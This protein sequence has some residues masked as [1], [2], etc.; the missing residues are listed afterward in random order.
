MLTISNKIELLSEKTGKTVYFIKEKLGITPEIEKELKVIDE[1][2]T[3][4]EITEV[5]QKY[6][7]SH[8]IVYVEI[9]RKWQYL[10]AVEEAAKEIL[11]LEK[12]K[13][14]HDITLLITTYVNNIQ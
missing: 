12:Q 10:T 13:T 4:D 9:C 1:I 3:V 5:L 2:E 7:K 14:N 6:Q 8:G 11:R